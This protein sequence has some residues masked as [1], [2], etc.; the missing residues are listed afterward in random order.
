MVIKK[1]I[2]IKHIILFII[3]LFLTSCCTITKTP[4]AKTFCRIGITSNLQ[5][6][7]SYWK[8]YYRQWADI[9]RFEV[10]K[11]FNSKEDAESFEKTKAKELGCWFGRGGGDPKKSEWIVYRIDLKLKDRI[12]TKP[13]E[14]KNEKEKN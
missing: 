8:T 3:G 6:R 12:I 13:E 7:K 9:K 1:N 5:D 14:L 2:Q 11:T 10:L 4:Q